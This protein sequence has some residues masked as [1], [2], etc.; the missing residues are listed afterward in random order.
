M[1]RPATCAGP[2]PARP[3][4]TEPLAAGRVPA[5]HRPVRHAES[6]KAS[7]T[8]GS[9][10]RPPGWYTAAPP[11]GEASQRGRSSAARSVWPS[12]WD[13]YQAFLPSD[14]AVESN[15]A[16]IG[17][18]RPMAMV[19]KRWQ[20]R[21]AGGH[22]LAGLAGTHDPQPVATQPR[23]QPA[24]QV[25]DPRGPPVEGR[26]LRGSAIAVGRFPR[27]HRWT[28]DRSGHQRH[29]TSPGTPGAGAETG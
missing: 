5:A 3:V 29:P 13:S 1:G 18:F 24:A 26:L 16:G 19:T 28:S 4:G 27:G 12:D 9:Y 20:C 6:I 14:G 2:K 7:L 10:R 23:P 22:H 11:A 8:A 21:R 25:A 17:D 15:R